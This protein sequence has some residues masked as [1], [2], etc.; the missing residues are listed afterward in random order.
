MRA[1]ERWLTGMRTRNKLLI[2]EIKAKVGSVPPAESGG[3]V[4]LILEFLTSLS[5]ECSV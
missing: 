1:E 2:F 5:D 3:E 4:F